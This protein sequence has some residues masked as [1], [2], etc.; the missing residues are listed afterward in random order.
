[1]MEDYQKLMSIA[2]KDYD[3]TLNRDPTVI[4]I[5][6]KTYNDSKNFMTPY[7][8]GYGVLSIDNHIVFELSQGKDFEE[9]NIYGVTVTDGQT[10]F[11]DDNRVFWE[12]TEAMKH[13]KALLKKYK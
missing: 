9:N 3:I 5:F 12:F 4:E 8:I 13:I 11:F 6:Q 10:R 7:V 1:M 2:Q